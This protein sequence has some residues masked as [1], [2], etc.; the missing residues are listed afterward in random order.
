LAAVVLVLVVGASA[1][2]FHARPLVLTIAFLGVNYAGLCAYEAGRIP[3]RRLFWL[4]PLY[5]VWTNSHGGMLG[6]LATMVLA[7]VG[8]AGCRV[9]GWPSPLRDWRQLAGFAGL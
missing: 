7:L 2:H 1:S 5:V 4:V 3:L 8:W 9:I 6:G